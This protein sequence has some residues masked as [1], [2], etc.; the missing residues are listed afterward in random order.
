LLTIWFKYGYQEE[1]SK[2][3]GDGIRGVNV[4]TWLQVIPQL[5]ARIHTQSLLVR[6]LILQLLCSVGKAHPQALLYSVTVASK[7]TNPSIRNSALSIVEDMRTHSPGLVEQA[8]LVSHELIRVAILW[9][10]MWHEVC[11]FGNVKGLEEASRHYYGVKNIEGMFSTLDPL[12]LMLERGAETQKEVQ[13]NQ[14]FGQNLADAQ[15]WCRK[16][17]RS[18]K[19]S[20]LDAA[21]DLY[22]LVFRKIN[23]QLP[24]LTTLELGLVSP[25]LQAAE[26][27]DIAVPGTYVSGQ[28]VVKIKIFS[29]TLNVITSKQ[30]PRK[31]NVKGSDGKDYPYLLKGM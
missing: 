8:L 5:I 27:L 17:K 13:F 21:W 19:Q 11:L 15:E 23:K 31:L 29:T 6:N 14:A 25:K 26:D 12:H 16:Y 3:V 22:Y 7:S 30:R 28:P 10:E 18:Q 9:S 1:V 24:Q 2:E 20:D 4:D